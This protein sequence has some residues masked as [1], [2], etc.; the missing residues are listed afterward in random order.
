MMPP[1]TSGRHPAHAGVGRR[2]LEAIGEPQD[3]PLQLVR[4]D[5]CGCSAS[6]RC[7]AAYMS[8]RALWAHRAIRAERF[9]GTAPAPASPEPPQRPSTSNCRRRPPLRNP[10]EFAG[11]SGPFPAANRAPADG[12]TTRYTRPRINRPQR[13][14]A[15]TERTWSREA[16]RSPAPAGWSDH[17]PLRRARSQDRRLKLVH[18][19]RELAERHY[20]VHRASRS[21]RAV[22]FITSGPLVAWLSKPDAIACVGR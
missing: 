10:A 4:G 12:W 3:L 17:R 15:V 19:D 5:A 14:I 1:S 7:R 18:V 22:A 8:W 2:V 11:L 13:C 6:R 20:A 9:R 16:R 21:S